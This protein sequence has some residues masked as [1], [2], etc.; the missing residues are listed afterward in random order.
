M[1]KEDVLPLLDMSNLSVPSSPSTPGTPGPR[2]HDLLLGQNSPYGT[3]VRRVSRGTAGNQMLD[4]QAQIQTLQRENDELRS[5]LKDC[6]ST[7][8]RTQEQRQDGEKRVEQLEGQVETALASRR[9]MKDA[10]ELE[11]D[12]SRNWMK[13][14]SELR[15]NLARQQDKMQALRNQSTSHQSNAERVKR[16]TDV[17]MSVMKKETSEIAKWKRLFHDYKE[18]VAS[19]LDGLNVVAR[20]R[21]GRSEEAIAN[22][23]QT[24]DQARD[25]IKKAK[26]HLEASEAERRA[27]I[28][29]AE[30]SESRD[31]IMSVES[32]SAIGVA[33]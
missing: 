25:I 12:N 21:L 22:S 19:Y 7:L 20:D 28:M 24:V 4:L 11:R 33:M 6:K 10:L 17:M 9:S 2:I 26:E 1:S 18:L 8:A 13:T 30:S 15:K 31:S 23:L 29:S 27:S 32:V 5:Q 3:T 14:V 16:F